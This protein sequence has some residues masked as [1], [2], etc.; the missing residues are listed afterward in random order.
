LNFIGEIGLDKADFLDY[1]EENSE[2][3]EVQEMI[4]KQQ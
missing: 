4:K 1:V 3:K 2:L